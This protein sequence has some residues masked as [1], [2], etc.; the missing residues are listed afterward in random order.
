MKASSTSP[1][2]ITV[3][4]SALSMATSVSALNCSVRQAWRPMSVA[5]VGQHDLRVP[6]PRSSSG[7]GHRVG[8]PWGWSRSRRSARHVPHRSPGCSPRP[9][10][11]FEQRGTLDAWHSRCS[12]PRCCCQ[13]RCAPAS[14]TG[15]PLRC[16]P[17]PSQNPPA[18]WGR[19]CRAGFQLASGQ[20]QRLVP[21]RF[22][23]GIA[24]VGAVG[25][26]SLGTPGLRISGTVRRSGWCAVKTKTPLHAQAALVGGPSRPSTLTIFHRARCR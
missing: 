20:V 23:E 25:R 9:S 15:R 6:R 8:W 1:S 24:P 21:G 2:S 18:P 19:G 12:G 4:I 3:W 14:G 10:H 13:S 11:A 17:W 7:R 26:T 22:A 16:C 5:R